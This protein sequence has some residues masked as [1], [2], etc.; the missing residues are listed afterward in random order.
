VALNCL[1]KCWRL[2]GDPVRGLR[3]G[4][5]RAGARPDEIVRAL[6]IDQGLGRAQDPR[7]CSAGS[8]ERAASAICGPSPLTVGGTALPTDHRSRVVRWSAP[9]RLPTRSGLRL[10]T[11][12]LGPAGLIEDRTRPAERFVD[13]S[14]ARRSAA[15][16]EAR[17][18]GRA[19]G[20]C[21]RRR[22]GRR[23]RND[24]TGS[25][26]VGGTAVE[27]GAGESCLIC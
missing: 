5:C 19:D 17:G 20:A 22:R 2:L 18:S 6:Q 23:P 13:S 12:A 11:A 14:S 10:N 21:L 26:R 3:F 24:D 7:G 9:G 8:V 1:I 15:K 27:L 25:D 16:Y 4:H